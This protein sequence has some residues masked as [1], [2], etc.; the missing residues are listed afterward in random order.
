MKMQHNGVSKPKHKFTTC[1]LWEEV[2]EE[3][4]ERA[5]DRDLSLSAYIKGLMELEDSKFLLNDS[6]FATPLMSILKRMQQ[7]VDQKRNMP[8]D[9]G[10][11]FRW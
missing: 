4:Q 1:K 11:S 8:Q 2:L 10:E 7:E 9:K 6:A 3:V 5:Y